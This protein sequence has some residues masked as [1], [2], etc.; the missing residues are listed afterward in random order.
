MGLKHN[1]LWD[2]VGLGGVMRK[3]VL[4]WVVLCVK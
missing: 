3:I 1:P 4:V 2:E